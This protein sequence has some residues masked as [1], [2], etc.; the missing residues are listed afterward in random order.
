MKNKKLNGLQVW[1]QFEDLLAPRLCQS[2]VDRAVYSHLLR[3][4]RLEGK[5]QIQFSMQWLARGVC[6]TAG[7][8]RCAVRRLIARGVLRLVERN[9]T[10]HCVEVRLP[11]EI[12]AIFTS[13]IPGR[14]TSR[15]RG[16]SIEE[17]DFMRRR[18]LRQA[19]HDRE[20]GR[21]F[22]CRCPVT[23]TMRCLDHV[24]PRV[25]VEDNSYRN[26]VSC[27][28]ECNSQKRGKS[29]GTFLRWLHRE[30]RLTA[31][32]LT[33]GLRSL[34]SLV[35]GKLRPILPN[36]G[37]AGM[38]RE[39]LSGILDSRQLT[40]KRKSQ[41]RNTESTETEHGGHRGEKSEGTMLLKV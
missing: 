11:E 18:D 22:Y 23:S 33:A 24:I 31:A 39:P 4:S 10:G 13:A 15:S 6:L 38:R 21:C 37:Q 8:V 30:R 19:I 17:L 14:D 28:V 25:E 12:P 16:D 29:A 2:T 5:R 7:P 40:A 35:A 1:K 36:L 9:Q 3:H 41:R 34:N 32:E 26:L 20:G 27:C